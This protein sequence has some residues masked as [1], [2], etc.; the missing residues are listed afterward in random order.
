MINKKF[1]NAG[2]KILIEE[3]LEGFEL[4]YFIFFDKNNF[5]IIGYALDHKRIKDGDIG[6]NTGGMGAFAPSKKITRDLDKLIQETIIQPTSEGLKKEN[7][8][9]RGVLFVGLMITKDGPKVIEYNVR[10]GDPECQVLMR[11]YKSDFLQDTY[12]VSRDSLNKKKIEMDNDYCVC[13]VLVSK[14]YPGRFIKNLE[15]KNLNLLKKKK[16]VEIFHS[17]TRIENNKFYS[18][19]G[20]VLSI[21]AKN[22]NSNLAR[23]KV[24]DILDK[25]NWKDGFYR[26]DIGSKNF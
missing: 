26:K 24:Y 5:S 11:Q 16:D 17:G 22:G 14:G 8:I 23:K 13:V 19:G 15:I 4:S 7:L 21:T 10:F 20:R 2:K 25:I 18:N 9:Y 12:A 3:Y 6:P 1:N